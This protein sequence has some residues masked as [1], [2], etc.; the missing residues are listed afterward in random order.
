MKAGAAV[1]SPPY[2]LRLPL[3]VLIS[4]ISLFVISTCI[5]F[6]SH[7]YFKKAEIKKPRNKVRE[8]G[9]RFPAAVET[10]GRTPQGCSENAAAPRQLLSN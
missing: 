8:H 9:L 5:F 4:T 1:F 6:Y 3:P 2:V 7:V 10:G